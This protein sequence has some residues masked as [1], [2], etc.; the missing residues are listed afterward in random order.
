[1]SYFAYCKS[2]M[3]LTILHFDWHKLTGCIVL[4]TTFNL[5]EIFNL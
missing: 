4:Y 2:Y 1:M 3:C 5:F